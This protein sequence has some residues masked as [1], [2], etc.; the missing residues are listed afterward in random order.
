M[1][2]SVPVRSA[3]AICALALLASPGLA[4]PTIL[5]PS[6]EGPQATGS[7][8]PDW[9]NWQNSPDTCDDSGPF[10]YTPNPW[11]LSPDGGTFVRAGGSILLSSE[12]IAQVVTGFTMGTTYDL[13]ASITNLGFQH[14]VDGD[15]LGEDGYWSLYI[16]GV[17]ADNS[18][19]LSKPVNNTDPINWTS[20]SFTFTAPAASFELALVSRSGS[21]LAAYMGIDGLRVSEVPAPGALTLGALVGVASLRRQRR[22]DS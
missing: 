13:S 11:T 16:D 10:N 2:S 4:V 19:T 18:A 7:A 6:L 9:Y 1:L 22:H 14:P 8:P 12:A 5:N 3:P 17:L 20:D 15:W 21:S